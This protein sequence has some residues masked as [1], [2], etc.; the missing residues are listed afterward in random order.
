VARIYSTNFCDQ[1]PTPPFETIV[2]Y[3][4]SDSD[5]IILRDMT[6]T[7]GVPPAANNSVP[8]LKVTFGVDFAVVWQLWGTQLDSGR[9]Y[10]WEGREVLNGVGALIATINGAGSSFR[11]NGYV[12]TP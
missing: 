12:L 1:G 5:V 2:S 10:M 4:P 8:Q 7:V 3:E 11:A 6:F 9:T